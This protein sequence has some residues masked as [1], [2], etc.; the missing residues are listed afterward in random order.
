MVDLLDLLH[1]VLL[2]LG[3]ALDLQQLLGLTGA[4]DQGSPVATSA[5]SR[6]PSDNFWRRATV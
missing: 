5:P 3:D 6:M 1:K 2:G 4:L